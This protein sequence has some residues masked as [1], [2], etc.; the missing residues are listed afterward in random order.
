[1]VWLK[2]WLW[3][4]RSILTFG[5]LPLPQPV[6]DS[7]A[8]DELH[9]V[10]LRHAGR[11]V[12]A[13]VDGEVGAP[14]QREVEPDERRLFV[15]EFGVPELI[16]GDGGSV[17]GVEL[18]LLQDGQGRPLGLRLAALLR[19]LQRAVLGG[20]ARVLRRAGRQRLCGQRGQ[21]D[22]NLWIPGEELNKF[23]RWRPLFTVKSHLVGS[24]FTKRKS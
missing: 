12:P 13:A 7:T 11:H 4:E 1:M 24:S 5:D 23:A 3:L 14:R 10:V 21:L 17:Q 2:L 18:A 15:P 6:V 16:W 20:G 19:R 9:E 22:G 8:L